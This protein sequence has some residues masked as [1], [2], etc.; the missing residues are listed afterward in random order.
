MA[1]ADI[2]ADGVDDLIIGAPGALSNRGRLYIFLG[3]N[4]ATDS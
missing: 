2:D 4:W 3:S 1:S